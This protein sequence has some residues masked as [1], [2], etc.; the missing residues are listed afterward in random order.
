MLLPRSITGGI[1]Y[2]FK[3]LIDLISQKDVLFSFDANGFSGRV[4][5]SRAAVIYARGLDYAP[6]S[7][8]T[9]GESYDFQKPHVEAWLRMIGVTDIDS[10]LI[11]RT[12]FGLEAEQ[13][14]RANAKIEA[15]RLALEF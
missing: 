11:E 15:E 14:A 7:T 9:P 6:T 2:R 5:A 12:L 4:N 3:Q 8:W 10:I 1:P 13:V